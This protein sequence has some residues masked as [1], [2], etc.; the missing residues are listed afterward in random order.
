[1][2]WI[3]GYDSLEPNYGFLYFPATILVKI[4]IF[5]DNRSFWQSKFPMIAVQRERDFANRSMW[6]KVLLFAG[7]VAVTVSEVGGQG[8]ACPANYE[9][10]LGNGPCLRF[11][12]A[13]D[14]QSYQDARQTC[15][16][17]GG[18]LVVIKDAALNTFIVDR[19]KA[20]YQAE[21]W[22][23]L[24]ELD[25]PPGVYTWSDGSV[26]QPGDFEDWSGVLNVQQPDSTYGE[27]C[28]EIR[29]PAPFLYDWN[30][31]HC[32]Y[33]KNY[34]CEIAPDCPC[35]LDVMFLVDGSSSIGS[36]GFALAKEYIAHFINCFDCPRIGFILCKCEVNTSI[37]LCYYDYVRDATTAVGE[38]ET[39]PSLT[40]IGYCI[41]HMQCTTDWK[42]GVPSI[43]VILTDG[44]IYGTIDGRYTEDVIGYAEA[45]R[46]AGME[47]YAGA[48]GREV[49]V[50]E[51]ALEEI[52]G[53]EDRTFSTF[54]ED[55]SVLV[56][57][58]TIRHCGYCYALVKYLPE[59][60]KC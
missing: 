9:R 19:I 17:E 21:T 27:E 6:W 45:A 12:A 35:D 25:G 33:R 44:R 32:R 7:L 60:R 16:G 2:N 10:A 22:I 39:C 8:D 23:G 5:S 37:P 46:D 53:S 48:I 49:F 14:R 47:V 52:S 40:R 4:G 54:D 38:I 58:L 24:D 20:T 43:V 55:P 15:E 18:R 51:T 36:E 28:V 13:A 3:P 56:A 59:K 41:K 31:H 29:A 34:V 30:N 57:I 1:M 26:L 42:E 50:D 11:S